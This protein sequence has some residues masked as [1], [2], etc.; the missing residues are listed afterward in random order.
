MG[1]VKI[2]GARDD[3]SA[4]IFLILALIVMPFILGYVIYMDSPLYTVNKI[5]QETHSSINDLSTCKYHLEHHYHFFKKNEEEYTKEVEDTIMAFC[6]RHPQLQEVREDYYHPTK[7]YERGILLVTKN[8]FKGFPI[9]KRI[10][11]FI[12][13]VVNLDYAK[14]SRINTKAAWQEYIDSHPKEYLRDA[15]DQ[16]RN[17]AQ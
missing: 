12:T 8:Y 15:K 13:E 14:A 3:G 2:E 9:E 17:C 10:D 16:L 1:I 6:R 11:A 5:R 4:K 7:T